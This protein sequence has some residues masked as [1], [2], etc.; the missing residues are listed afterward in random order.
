MP[1]VRIGTSGWKYPHWRGNFYP[2]G[3]PAGEQLRYLAQHV[4]SVEIN[5]SFYAL[6]TPQ[7]Y[8]AWRDSTPP[9]FQFAVKGSRYI[10]HMK[11]LSDPADA[12]RRFFASGVYELGDEL[13]PV[14]WQLPA[15]LAFEYDRLA[16]FLACLPPGRH[17][18]EAR[19]ASFD[20]ARCVALL[21]DAAVALVH[22]DSAGTFPVFDIATTDFVY[23]RLHGPQHL[24]GGS[25]ATQIGRWAQWVERWRTSGRDV[26]VYFDNDADGAAPFDAMALRSATSP[27]TAWPWPRPAGPPRPPAAS[28]TPEAGPGSSW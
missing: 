22:A 27:P 2:E 25:Y 16:T 7:R 3:L 14:L 6:Q 8:A 26:Y 9:D 5:A 18:V 13:G 21:E 12:V 15:T 23:A 20:D 11:R 19:H 4:D 28:G 17:A 24:Y 10:T 1:E